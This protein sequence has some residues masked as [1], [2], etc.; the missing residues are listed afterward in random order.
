[1]RVLAALGAFANPNM[2]ASPL[3]K[4]PNEQRPLTKGLGKGSSM[5]RVSDLMTANPYTLPPSASLD[6]LLDIME[7]KSIRHVPVLEPDG[8]LVGIASDRD[9]ARAAMDVDEVPLS[10]MR[11]MLRERCVADVMTKAPQTVSPEDTI[12][13]AGELMTDNK[14]GCLPVVEGDMLVGILTESDFVRHVMQLESD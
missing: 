5:L 7:S 3:L 6:T 1:M 2:L 4:L 10:T 8:T 11:H 13:V 14:Y 12:D 9:L